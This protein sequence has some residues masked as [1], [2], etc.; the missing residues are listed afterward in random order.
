MLSWMQSHEPLTLWEGK[1]KLRQRWILS[2]TVSFSLKTADKFFRH[3]FLVGWSCS[4]STSTAAPQATVWCIASAS[5]AD[6][7]TCAAQATAQRRLTWRALKQFM[8]TC[9]TSLLQISANQRVCTFCITNVLASKSLS[10]SGR[11]VFVFAWSCG[12]IILYTNDQFTS[13]SSMIWC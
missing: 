9:V 13:A 5:R 11:T 6:S 1:V 12:T 8:L 7:C 2:P 3:V 4:K 10:W